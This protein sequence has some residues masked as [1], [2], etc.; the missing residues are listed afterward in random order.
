MRRHDREIGKG[1]RLM[2]AAIELVLADGAREPAGP[3]AYADRGMLRLAVRAV[4][5]AARSRPEVVAARADHEGGGEV[6][7]DRMRAPAK[8]EA[9]T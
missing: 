8:A 1:V 7:V 9:G 4:L 6:R 5:Q 2:L 3:V